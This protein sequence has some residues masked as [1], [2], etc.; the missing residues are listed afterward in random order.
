MIVKFQ[1]ATR[2]IFKNYITR[3]IFSQN[4]MYK[5]NIVILQ[6][7]PYQPREIR[8]WANLLKTTNFQGGGRGKA[9]K[10]CL[11]SGRRRSVLR[12][13]YQARLTIR[14]AAKKN[15]IPGFRNINW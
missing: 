9:R 2:K 7:I 15:T 11:I 5:R 3:A 8:A 6:I 10:I 14:D 12:F 13:F 4:E 1:T